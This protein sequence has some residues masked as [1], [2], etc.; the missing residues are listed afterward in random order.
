MSENL[1]NNQMTSALPPI[2]FAEASVHS[3]EGESIFDS[4]EPITHENVSRYLNK[5]ELIDKAIEKLKNAG[6]EV[7]HI[8]A[9]TINIAASPETYEKVFHTK[10]VPEEREVLKFGRKSTATILDD[11]TT[12]LSGLIDT[13]NSDLAD[14]LEGVAINEPVY[15]FSLGDSSLATLERATPFEST[16]SAMPPSV[17]GFYLNVPDD[18]ARLLKADRVHAT[19]ITGR[20]VRVVMVDSGWFRHPYFVQRGYQ[21]N[22][23]VLAPGAQNPAHDESGHGT[24]ESANIFAVAPDVNFTMVKQGGF[25]FTSAIVN[26]TGDFNKALELR[27]DI[28]SCSWGFDERERRPLS[29]AERTL[30]AAI[31]NAVSQGVTVV[32]SAGNGHFGFPG[33][34]P[35]VISAGGVF[36]DSDGSMRA[37]DYASGF[38]SPLFPGRKVPDVC[39]L[40]G[41]Q[42]RAQ[43]IMLPVE[44]GDELDVEEAR[45]D[46]R[47]G[48]TLVDGTQ[49][50]DGWA[51]F[52]GTSAAAPQLAGICALL[53]QANPSLTPQ[54]M[55]ETLMNTAIDITEGHNA[56]NQPARP[57]NDLATGSGLANAEKAVQMVRNVH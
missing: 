41:M 37:S 20:G 45:I 49:P 53:K 24:G 17:E 25:S 12:K 27:P 26:A 40:V 7:L 18:V 38:E 22:Q 43:Y 3:I 39:G 56:Q 31:A 8:G 35:D 44:P 48:S 51:R 29:A 57:G 54:R 33:Q 23:V 1:T 13:S 2:I 21:A 34:H 28:I 46:P 42:P 10:I 9:T 14:V 15:Y 5:P 19:G 47:S 30:S 36:V 32:F 52:S 16:L 4:T 50:K 11:P 6:F 55:K